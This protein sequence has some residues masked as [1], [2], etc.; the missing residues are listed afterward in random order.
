MPLAFFPDLDFPGIYIEIPYQGSTPEE[1]ERLITRPA[2]EVLATISGIKQMYTDS[3]E[4]EATIFLEF[5]WGEET[6]TKALE[7]KEKLNGIRHIFPDDLDRI[8]VHSF[9]TADWPILNFRI[10]SNRDLSGSY[11]LL[12]RM[13]KRRVERL[14]GVSKVDLYGIEPREIRI[15]MDL[16]RV[17]AHNIDLAVLVRDLRQANF[18]TTAGRI[19]ENNRRY[20]VRP[21]GE[22]RTPEEFGNL[23]ISDSKLRLRDIASVSYDHPEQ[24]Y[25]RHLDRKP[26]VGLDVF[27]TTG[28]NTVEVSERVVAEIED[29]TKLPEMD[30]IK[31]IF[32][33]NQ[34]EG[35]V[36]SLNELLKAGMLGAVMAML[37][38]YFFLRRLATTLIVAL[39]VP[40]SLVITLGL[41]YFMD[42]NLNI[43]SMMGLM[44]AV[45]ML[46]DNAVVIT[47]NIHRR[48]HL[49]GISNQS[50]LLGVKEVGLAVAAGTFTT[51]I[52]FL[53]NIISDN[54]ELAIQMKHVAL[55]IVFAL[56]AS[57]LI[58][59]T[60]VPLLASRIKSRNSRQKQTVI[61][62]LQHKYLKVLRWT[63]NHHRLSMLITLLVIITAAIPMK[64][65]K[66]DLFEEGSNKRLWLRYH[67][68]GD[69]A[70]DKVEAAVDRIE[71]YLF[72]NQEEFQI[73]SVYS[74]FNTNYANSTIYLLDDKLERPV[75]EIKEA[76]MEGMPQLAIGEPSLDRNRSSG[77]EKIGIQ[78]VGKSSEEL[79]DLSSDVVRLL[80][81]ASDFESVRSDAEAGD[82]EVQV[83]IRRDRARQYGLSVG[84]IAQIVSTAMRG[85]NLPK[86]RGDESEIDLRLHFQA[87]DERTI[88]DLENLPLFIEGQ[89]PITLG[90]VADL[91]IKKG[92][93]N[94]HREN[95]ITSMSV[96]ANLGDMTMDDAKKKISDIMDLYQF[97]PGYRWT[98]GSAFS[99]EDET[100]RNMMVNTLMA[101]AMIYFVMAALFESLVF[102]AAIWSSIL[103]AIIGV[104]WFFLM[105]GTTF[106]LM[107]W[108]GVL[109][110]MGVV[111]NNGI[112]LIDHVNQL[113]GQ[114][115]K[116]EDAIAQAGFERLRPIL[117]TAA[118]TVLG[119]VP[120]SLSNTQ[121]GGEGPPYY[122]MARAIVGGLTFSTVVTL[123]ILPTI[124]IMLD[125]MRVWARRV[126]RLARG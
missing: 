110:L 30:G 107:A 121:I 89:S 39:A 79:F 55:S 49:D 31:I 63:L 23:I 59:L 103:F 87:V 4:N 58:A 69:Y 54:N 9:S 65:V 81:T 22:L 56:A 85:M 38:L 40:S 27:K 29:I 80:K 62:A 124:Y 18:M 88:S 52:V 37:V 101:L 115:L 109:I 33:D 66:K 5:N 8:Y 72:A 116:R 67:I 117:M 6:M 105:T 96:N 32:L 75:S 46:V 26:A 60:V 114:G 74:Y 48:H 41:L 17:I 36:S 97:P 83:V 119:L 73:R 28:S 76:I 19:D 100:G 91:T 24:F 113:R 3:R 82:E 44:L 118:T 1:V 51:A 11:D 45:G 14:D 21:I 57:L 25:G 64:F 111:V 84:S 94:I 16:D 90:A 34:G 126:I 104:W 123:L 93:R 78:L 43:L 53:P 95:R 102:P 13:L 71:E 99:Y 15:E 112:V 47:E 92:P 42:L 77:K 61:D 7:S 125:D 108:I 12:N 68:T 2:E 35:I 98:F 10:S 122:P 50:T 70:L 20:V 106:S 86:V 120:L